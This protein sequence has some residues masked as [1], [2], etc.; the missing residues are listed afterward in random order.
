LQRFKLNIASSVV[1]EQNAGLSTM[2]TNQV[3][4]LFDVTDTDV[5][6][7]ATKTDGPVSQSE[8]LKGYAERAE[9][10]FNQPADFPIA[11]SGRSS[12]RGRVRGTLAG[13]FHVVD[14]SG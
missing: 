5:P 3:L 8:L 9:Y 6:S 1:N 11:Q 10:R 12:S 4:D 13:R 2:N 7:A 14:V